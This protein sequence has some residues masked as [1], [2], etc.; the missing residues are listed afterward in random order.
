VHWEHLPIALWPSK[1]KGEEH[2][3][4]GCATVAKSGQLMLFYTSIGKRAPEQWAAVPED[5]ELINWKKHPLNPLMTEKLHGDTRV[6]EWRDPFVFHHGD[7]TYLVCGG[8]LNNNAGG[9]AAVLVYRAEN[10]EL[11]EWKYLGVLFQHP[12]AAVKNI[13]CPLFFPLVDKSGKER[14]VLV[15]SPHA[16]VQY[17]VGDLDAETMKFKAETRGIVDH[18][19]FYAPNVAFD[20]EGRCLLWGWIRDFPGGKGWNGCL[21]VPRELSLDKDG[22][23]HQQPAAE[24]D[25]LV[26]DNG[27]K[28]KG[29][30]FDEAL[31][32]IISS[33]T[34][35]YRI[36]S[37]IDRGD[38]TEIVIAISRGGDDKR[39]VTIRY[40]GRELDVAGTK[41][42]LALIA[43]EPLRLDVLID[44]SVLEVYANG[45]ACVSRVIPVPDT[46]MSVTIK[47]GV[48]KF[49][50]CESWPMSTI[51][52]KAD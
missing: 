39:E 17:F 51:W 23:L 1:S 43:G 52:A 36:R 33:D 7:K 41:V 42:P 47:D 29:R 38:K 50:Y 25:K 32:K 28:S 3:F 2:C 5:R 48:S 6:Y 18:G 24:L 26:T 31:R 10:D 46:G 45:R 4:S 14:W 8:N 9:Q 27:L 34:E 21:T 40:R 20:K 44:H 13:E 22:H 11:S 15:V 30:D 19:S 12:D 37:I 16:P 49:N 35:A